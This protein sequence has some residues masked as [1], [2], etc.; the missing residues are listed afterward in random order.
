MMPASQPTKNLLIMAAGTGGHIFPGLAIADAMRLRGWQ[1]S[2]LGTQSGMETDI[3]PRYKIAM[4]NINFS[5]L[6]GKGIVHTL[7]GAL[8]LVN[9]F[10]TCWR[11]FSRRQ[12][13]LILGMGGYVTVPGGL[14]AALRGKPLVLMN[15]DATLLLSNKILRPLANKILFGLPPENK[16][17]ANKEIVTGN[18]IRNDICQLPRPQER[19]AARDG[20]LRILVVG[21]SLG[22]KVLNE[23]I[24]AA[25]AL[26]AEADRPKIT[27]QSGKNHIDG[28]RKRYTQFGID[29]EFVDFINDM[30]ERYAEA[31]LVICRAGAITVSELTAAGVASILIPFIASSTSHQIDNARWMAKLGAA[32]HLPQQ[33]L[34]PKSLAEIL[35]NMTRERCARMAELAYASGQRDASQT[36]A[37]ILE[38]LA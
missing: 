28:L 10:F 25:I 16:T 11:I 35:Q 32:T 29:A 37:T 34:N 19:Y 1:V 27:H 18:A 15:A 23:T 5:G 4:D 7:K 30:P 17:S 33:E 8:K 31:D 36:I 20:V 12:P 3:V 24:P 6:R 2:W 38:K 26:M 9:S 13:D 22:A 21:G 14:I